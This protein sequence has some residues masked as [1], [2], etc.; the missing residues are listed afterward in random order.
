MRINYIVIR[1]R[2]FTLI[3][4]F[5]GVYFVDIISGRRP[6]NVIDTLSIGVLSKWELS[7]IDITL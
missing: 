2:S 5:E 3:K 7:I 1:E 4:I 6:E